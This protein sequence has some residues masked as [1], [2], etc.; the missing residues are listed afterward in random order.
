M[1]AG[2]LWSG[3]RGDF[4]TEYVCKKCGPRPAYR[5]A[6]YIDSTGTH[7]R[8]PLCVSCY[9]LD[10]P[11]DE[12]PVPED[13]Q[14]PPRLMP[15]LKLLRRL[16]PLDLSGRCPRCNRE[17]PVNQRCRGYRATGCDAFAPHFHRICVTC[18]QEVMEHDASRPLR[19]NEEVA[20]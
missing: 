11:I 20:A 17:W 5:F 9:A 3:A 13:T 18:S 1:S 16:P 14:R 15:A 2:R 7:R 8:R 19:R 4:A 10:H 12:R 6:V